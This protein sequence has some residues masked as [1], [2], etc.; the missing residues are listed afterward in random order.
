[1][2]KM[3]GE[4]IKHAQLKLKEFGFFTDRIDGYF[5]QNLL[6]AVTNFQRQAIKFT[7]KTQIKQ[8]PNKNVPMNL[9]LTTKLKS[10]F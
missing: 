6:I 7:F 4:D 2:L 5:G 3:Y 9:L 1:M 10:L 8:S